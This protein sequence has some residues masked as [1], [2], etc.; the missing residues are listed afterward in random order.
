MGIFFGCQICEKTGNW[1]N[2]LWERCLNFG[3]IKEPG[4]LDTGFVMAMRQQAL[5]LL[6][7]KK[8]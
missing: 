7:V 6:N 8:D 1:G 4:L 5:I 2:D 3:L